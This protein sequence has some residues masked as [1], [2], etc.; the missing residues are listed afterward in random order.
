MIKEFRNFNLSNVYMSIGKGYKAGG[1]N[2]QMFSE[3]LQERLMQY[4]GVGNRKDI[5]QLVSYK[6]EKSWNYE[7]GA[8]LNF[9]SCGL[10]TDVSLFYIDC[11]DQQM[12]V[13]P[14]G[15]TTGRMMTNAAKTRSFGGEISLY[16]TPF[17]GF[18]LIATYGY[19][20]ARFVKFLNGIND[21][22]G[23]RI[24]Y[25]PSNTVFCEASYKIGVTKKGD[26]YVNLGINYNG[27]GDIYWNE[28][29]T[30]RQKFYSL[31]GATLAYHS[32]KWSIEI[33][34]KNLTHTNYYTFYFMSMGN[35]F[36]QKGNPVQ[37]G[38]ILRAKF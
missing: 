12:T 18:N 11:F 15:Q 35:E 14:E 31:I 17:T 26:K 13:F 22:K 16:A 20:N 33:Y 10:K 9:P 1:F 19:T 38:V 3:V 4:M 32:P 7:I 21:Y 25:A 27:V 34:G 37:V 28:A 8:H 30:L 29:N 2:T 36:R 24:P 6:P 5:D 23:K